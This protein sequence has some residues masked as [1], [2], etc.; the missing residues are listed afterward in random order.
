MADF[1]HTLDEM[2]RFL[3]QFISAVVGEFY[4]LTTFAVTTLTEQYL[5]HEDFR[6][7]LQKGGEA[8]LKE[9]QKSL[10]KGEKFSSLRVPDSMVAD[11]KRFMNDKNVLY[12]SLND[13]E[14]D[15]HGFIFRDR[16]LDKMKEIKKLVE[17]IHLGETEIE[18]NVF[19]DAYEHR[20]ISRVTK[21]S[22]AEAELFRYFIKED[23]VQFALVDTGTPDN[24]MLLHDPKAQVAVREALRR[25]KWA[26]RGNFGSRVKEQVEYRLKGRQAIV[27][28]LEDARKE[29]YIVSKNNPKNYVHVTEH[30]VTTYKNEQEIAKVYRNDTDFKATAWDMIEGISSPTIFKPEEFQVDIGIRQDLLDRKMS[31]NEFPS[32]M[33]I[34]EEMAKYNRLRDLASYKMSMDDENQG[35]WALYVDSVS[36]SEFSTYENILDDDEDLAQKREFERL[37]Q[38]I[39]EAERQHEYEEIVVEEKS[40]DYIISSAEQ[41]VEQQRKEKKQA[42]ARTK[43]KSEAFYK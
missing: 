43:E 27:Q 25:A 7:L 11:Y 37:K 26:L 28:D 21:L 8:T 38:V 13:T 32:E 24:Y 20:N 6:S 35:N 9:F 41:R 12:V 29:F 33:I 30:E 5:K 2:E 42:R 4:A 19:L 22:A 31:L 40:L 16:D 17:M 23:K 18:P 3:L 39:K 36:Y 14:N 1:N 34:Q 10:K 15:T